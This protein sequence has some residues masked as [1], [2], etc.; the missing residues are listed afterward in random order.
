M[1]QMY[2]SSCPVLSSIQLFHAPQTATIQTAHHHAL[3]PVQTFF[4]F[5]AP[6][7]RIAVW[8]AASVMEA[9]C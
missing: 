9:L 2:N 8:K 1:P 4:P 5:S 7:H 6:C 3:L